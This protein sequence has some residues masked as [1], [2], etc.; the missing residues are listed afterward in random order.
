[1]SVLDAG[2]STLKM[3]GFAAPAGLA[4]SQVVVSTD[5][6]FTHCSVCGVDVMGSETDP[7]FL[8]HL[9]GK[10]HKKKQL[11]RQQQ[12]VEQGV[13]N[14]STAA[15]CEFQ[16][17][18]TTHESLIAHT[19]SPEFLTFASSS[20]TRDPKEIH[21]VL[22]FQ[23]TW[24]AEL[25][26]GGRHA[27]LAHSIPSVSSDRHIP[28]VVQTV[29]AY[30]ADVLFLQNV[31]DAKSRDCHRTFARTVGV[32]E[33]Y[34]VLLSPKLPDA[35]PC[36]RHLMGYR[37]NRYKFAGQRVVFLEK[38]V[39]QRSRFEPLYREAMRAGVSGN[40]DTA[41]AWLVLLEDLATSRTLLLASVQLPHAPDLDVFRACCFRELTR[42]LCL[43]CS[44]AKLKHPAV[45]IVGCFNA[46]PSSVC[47]ALATKLSAPTTDVCS[48]AMIKESYEARD[49]G[50]TSESADLGR[51]KEI[52][53]V[54]W[55]TVNVSLPGQL[56]TVHAIV[57]DVTKVR[58]VVQ[59]ATSDEASAPEMEMRVVDV[60][61]WDGSVLVPVAPS[62]G[63]LAR[64]AA[65][66]RDSLGHRVP[67]SCP[68]FVWE[69]DQRKGTVTWTQWVKLDSS[70]DASL[71]PTSVATSIQY[72]EELLF[73]QGSS[74]G[75]PT[76]VQPGVSLTSPLFGPRWDDSIAG[77]FRSAYSHYETV[78][79]HSSAPS[80][81]AS[82]EVERAVNVCGGHNA[83][84]SVPLASRL[85][86]G[87]VLRD[88]V[89]QELLARSSANPRSYQ[90][91]VA[92]HATT[93]GAE[94]LRAP[95]AFAAAVPLRTWL[96]DRCD[97]PLCSEAASSS[98]VSYEPRCTTFYPP[99]THL[100][101][102]VAPLRGQQPTS[103]NGSGSVVSC[104]KAAS[105]TTPFDRR[106]AAQ[107]LGQLQLG[108]NHYVLYMRDRL[109]VVGLAEVPS[110]EALHD[111]RNQEPPAHNETALIPSVHLPLCADLRWPLARATVSATTH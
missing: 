16:P 81:F 95:F 58:A 87:R 26:S 30:K 12:L 110:L 32:K 96:S 60:S 107:K 15:S 86:E 34:E 35:Q 78:R 65:A 62:Q 55:F 88:A 42:E 44:G 90:N 13:V 22:T 37:R 97:S 63:F 53:V 9:N 91:E 56:H 61:L 85:E 76:A 45:V 83:T 106:R 1:M 7:N 73:L 21:R 41:V 43:I 4:Q 17:S 28:Q 48:I 102:S 108:T 8:Q 59:E 3:L 84:V 27:L 57:M 2:V 79:R 67:L 40:L 49:T 75:T 89:Y 11:Q 33:S 46:A 80:S 39:A 23:L 69:T 66:A 93:S 92:A 29:L 52:E 18:S 25:L 36:V 77:A 82:E 24:E 94:T 111:R 5:L 50:R 19:I 71:P 103:L 105:F 38:L 72:L 64:P 10:S 31:V 74:F 47:Y 6:V 68:L 109:E 54:V 51:W 101:A 104:G 100:S 70:A 20:G 99:V 14:D 98:T